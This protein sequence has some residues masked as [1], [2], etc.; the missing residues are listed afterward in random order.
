MDVSY[1]GF[2]IRQPS[3]VT[4]TV[5]HPPGDPPPAVAD[6]LADRINRLEAAP[7]G[8]ETEPV[9]IEV[10]YVVVERA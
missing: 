8:L 5:G 4:V 9:S 3:E 2:P 6:R 1:D 7:F 10:R